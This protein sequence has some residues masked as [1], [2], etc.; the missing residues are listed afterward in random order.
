MTSD[1]EP[2]GD[3]GRGHRVCRASELPPGERRIVEIDGVSVGVFN[4]DGEFYALANV[5]PHQ[6]AALCSG[7][8]TGIVT[9]S[10]VGEFEWERDGEIIRC[11]RHKWA[12]DIKTGESIFNPVLNDVGHQDVER[13]SNR[14]Q[15]E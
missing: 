1:G 11:P 14:C 6:L 13:R 7:E 3:A 2:A 4:I 15:H 5:C 9:S 8:I 12:F 10:G